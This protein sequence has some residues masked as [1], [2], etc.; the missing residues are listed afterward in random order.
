M[1]YT[2]PGDKS[3]PDHVKAMPA[4]QRGQWVTV[5]ND[6][7]AACKG[8]GCEG[9]AM[10]MANGVAAGK[11]KKEIEEEERLSNALDVAP[12][13]E[14]ERCAPD[15]GAGVIVDTSGPAHV[16]VQ[17]APKDPMD[18][19]QSFTEIDELRDARR[20]Q[21]AREDT[22]ADFRRL[23]NNIWSD[24]E[25]DEVEKL[26]RTRRLEKEMAQRIENPQM[27]MKGLFERAKDFGKRLIGAGEPPSPEEIGASGV[28]FSF[29][30]LGGNWRWLSLTSNRF[31]DRH[32]EVF[33]EAAHKEYVDYVDRTGDYP[34]LRIWH[35]PGSDV[36]V[37]DF[38]AYS[39]GF[40]VDS[41]P[42]YKEYED[43]A[44]R[45]A[46]AEPQG[47]SHG[48][49]YPLSEPDG[50]GVYRRY[51]SFEVSV[52]PFERASNPWGDPRSKEVYGMALDPKKRAYLERF[53]EPARVKALEERLPQM[54]AALKD[55]GISWREAAAIGEA[56]AGEKAEEGAPEGSAPPA[57]VV[58]AAPAAPATPQAPVAAAEQ[59]A[60][61]A[62]GSEALAK[63]TGALDQI[64]AGVTAVQTELAGVKEFVEGLETRVKGLEGDEDTKLGERALPR[65]AGVLGQPGPAE[66]PDTLV[67][68]EKQ[69]AVGAALKEAAGEGDGSPADPY[70]AQIGIPA[71]GDAGPK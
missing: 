4:K 31:R 60:P 49:R 48:F 16:E 23:F 6:T 1:P 64:Q 10:K 5:F 36:G 7:M 70:L 15:M 3:L 67:P 52:L 33:S 57:P 55:A 71:G 26:K 11:G 32:G 12:D 50:N 30:D 45:L 20:R 41:G 44:E 62:T 47:V 66:S 37:A 14:A 13:G 17:E 39:D 59:E 19:I 8:D 18:G 24:D 25:I 42:Y 61:A 29:K 34:K 69:E 53:I 28:F 46:E 21:Y 40:R 38:V 56:L 63:V 2:G 43:V 68:A 65:A 58:P 22:I 27:A 35:V 9:K 51:R 54:E